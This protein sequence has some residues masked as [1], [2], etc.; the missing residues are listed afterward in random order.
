MN[1]RST[2]RVVVVRCRNTTPRLMTGP[3]GFKTESRPEPHL[4]DV[5]LL[6]AAAPKRCVWGKH[7]G[8]TSQRLTLR[9]C[10]SAISKAQLTPYVH[11]H[12]V[13]RK[14]CLDQESV[15]LA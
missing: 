3:R 4:D 15:L 12:D 13:V 1:R 9:F 7:P 5:M 11:L 6:A 10:E 8:P 14:G 2:P